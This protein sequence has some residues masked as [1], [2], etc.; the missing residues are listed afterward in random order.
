MTN[1]Q[2]NYNFSGNSHKPLILFLH[3]FMGNSYEFDEAIALLSNQFYCL[4]IDLPGHG[5][6]KL[7]GSDSDYSYSMA[8]TA[9]AVIELLDKLQITK[10]FLVGYSMGGRLALYL[11]LNF[12]DRFSK[13]V[14]ESA[15][16][17]LRTEA[18]RLERM[19][20]DGE[21]ARKLERIREKNDFADFLSN[22]YNQSIFGSIKN[23]PVFKQMLE[24]RL[25]NNPAELA[26]SLRLMGTGSQP[27]LWKKLPDNTNPLLLLVGE[28]DEKFIKIN[29]KITEFC[30][31]C[32]LQVISNAAHNIHLENT[33]AFIQNLKFFLNDDGK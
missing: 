19:K 20:S 13:V 18:E 27:S 26:K 3:G 6:T 23:H 25:H 2:F 9:C 33:L 22:W 12:R 14:L 7:L 17:G 21:I 10:C 8:N 28:N 5:K 31:F 4:T 30:N 16:P 1:T 29:L 11:T 24:S 15:S 32:H